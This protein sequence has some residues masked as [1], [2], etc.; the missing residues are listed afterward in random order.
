MGEALAVRDKLADICADRGLSRRGSGRA[1]GGCRRREEEASTPK[2]ATPHS[3]GPTRD[4]MAGRP[5]RGAKLADIQSLVWSR[6]CLSTSI[7]SRP[8][9]PARAAQ[10]ST[11]A[12]TS[13]RAAA[14]ALASCRSAHA[15]ADPSWS[16][17]PTATSSRRRTSPPPSSA[18][19]PTD[20][21]PTE[22]PSRRRFGAAC[23]VCRHGT[24]HTATP[25]NRSAL[26]GCFRLTEF[27]INVVLLAARGS[28]WANKSKSRATR[29]ER[30]RRRGDRRRA[31]DEE[32]ELE[33]LAACAIDALLPL[34]ARDASVRWKRSALLG[35]GGVAVVAS[36]A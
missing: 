1:R 9:S 6:C 36:T 21:A 20:P 2:E 25:V 17:S 7:R 29:V 22:P 5:P 3:R 28:K 13:W 15:C 10:R 35:L 11:M 19:A 23:R 32:L 34:G 27:G 33:G 14:S 18:S 16:S 30:A 12:R 31:W 26:G 8:V 24:I 4:P